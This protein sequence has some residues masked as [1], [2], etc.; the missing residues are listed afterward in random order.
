MVIW[1]IGYIQFC[2][3]E[4]LLHEAAHYNLFGNK[5]LHFWLQPLYAY[6]FFQTLKGFQG[7]HLLHH[8]DLMG[9][10]D[11]TVDDYRR[12]GLDAAEPNLFYIWFIKPFLG[13]PTWYYLRSGPDF[14]SWSSRLQLA[15]FWLP[16]LFVCSSLG[17]L[18]LILHYWFLP[19]IWCF[20][21]FQYWSEIEEHYNTRS[22]ARSNVSS[23]D[24]FFK[25]NEGYHWIHHRYPSIPFHQLPQAH[26]AL[27]PA[28]TDV[29]VGFL[30]TY[31]QM[32]RELPSDLSP[33]PQL[34]PG[35]PKG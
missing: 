23:I 2:L 32:C 12:Y 25:H 17:C 18:N 33:Y 35:G 11:Q 26:A 22:G 13:G 8:S 10:R 31:Q 9:P 6:P 24:N 5:R 21:V 20:P 3:G 19:L 7:E 1:M 15:A 14:D 30:H 16:L 4:A 29:S 27:I 28:N 34:G